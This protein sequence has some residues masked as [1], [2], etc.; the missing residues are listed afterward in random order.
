M[1]IT[2]A[3]QKQEQ[4]QTIEEYATNEANTLIVEKIQC[5]NQFEAPFW[6]LIVEHDGTDPQTLASAYF[7]KQ[8]DMDDYT[9]GLHNH[10][11]L[12]RF[13]VPA[14][15]RHFARY[16]EQISEENYVKVKITQSFQGF[17]TRQVTAPAIKTAHTSLSAG[18]EGQKKPWYRKVI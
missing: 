11:R 16:Q 1:A 12:K 10:H 4:V 3:P 18:E 6:G 2:P 14:R 7:A 15:M 13:N 9:D 17:L 5:R 8:A